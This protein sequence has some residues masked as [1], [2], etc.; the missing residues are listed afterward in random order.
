M[1]ILAAFVGGVAI[2]ALLVA[3]VVYG[4]YVTE[5]AGWVER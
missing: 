5:V 3:G 1:T 4:W 2:G